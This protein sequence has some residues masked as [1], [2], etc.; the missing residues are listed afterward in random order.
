MVQH[1]MY[2]LLLV[3]I[4]IFVRWFSFRRG[5]SLTKL[6]TI[7]I[8]FTSKINRVLTTQLLA[9]DWSPRCSH[10]TA[11]SGDTSELLMIVYSSGV[12]W[13]RRFVSW[14]SDT[15]G[16]YAVHIHDILH[17]QH[18]NQPESRVSTH[19]GAPGLSLS[20]WSYSSSNG[21]IEWRPEK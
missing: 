5:E 7:L 3:Y 21:F 12:Y 1:F 16:G 20:K 10:T 2:K 18:L 8:S 11:R 17:S 15:W 13:M 9:T 19:L 4:P 14:P 6:I